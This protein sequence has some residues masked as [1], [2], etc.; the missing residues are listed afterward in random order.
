[1]EHSDLHTAASLPY[2][3]IDPKPNPHY[4]R[5]LMEDYAGVVSE[6]SAVTQYEYQDVVTMHDYPE[7]AKMMSGVAMVEMRHLHILAQLI[8]KLG[9]D[10]LYRAHSN[11][12]MGH[13]WSGQN[14]KYQRALPQMILLNIQ[15]E[16]MAIEN[17]RRHIRCIDDLSV[18]RNLQRIILDE[19]QHIHL[20]SQA[21]S[22][23]QKGELH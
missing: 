2:P 22:Q 11:P 9:G 17:Y 23:W 21:L 6:L 19:E 12:T 5:V 20:F 7:F 1:M 8:E 15:G 18:Q 13:F 10:P 16:K 4:A 3:P 14:V